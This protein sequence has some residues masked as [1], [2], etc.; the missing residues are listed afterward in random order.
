MIHS[1]IANKNF[2]KN[3]DEKINIC[4]SK[5][6]DFDENTPCGRYGINEDIYVNVSEYEPKSKTSAAAETHSVY[7]D[8]Q[9]ILSGDEYIGYADT[10]ELS[11]KTDYDG[12]ND[13]R[14]W[15]GEVALLSMQQGDWA[16]FMPEEAHAPG[17]FKT[18]RR[19]KK[20]VF[21]IKYNA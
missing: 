12:Q 10:R 19:V 20:A 8:I 13:I 7:A 15:Q 14:F 1:N 4:L 17:L 18:S 5:M 11:P 3:L 2:Y 16:L 21:K 6:S 9:L